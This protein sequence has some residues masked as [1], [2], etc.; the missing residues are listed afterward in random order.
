MNCYLGFTASDERFDLS[1]H[2]EI[3]LFALS[4]GIDRIYHFF[5][6]I[7]WDLFVLFFRNLEK[8]ISQEIL[9]EVKVFFC[10]I[11]SNSI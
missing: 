10:I 11:I 5:D 9:H 7:Q 6:D 4:N 2:V 1:D 3:P 8:V